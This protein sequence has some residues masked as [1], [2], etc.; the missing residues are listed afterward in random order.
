MAQVPVLLSIDDEMLIP[1]P[2]G[3]EGPRGPSGIGDS[4]DIMEY[5]GTTTGDNT[6][7]LNEA[8]ADC[9]TLGKRMISFPAGMFGFSS[10]PSAIDGIR[11]VGQG[12]TATYLVRNYSGNFLKF[13]GGLLGGSGLE[14]LGVLAGSGTSGGYGIHLVGSSTETP[15]FSTFKSLLVSSGGGTFAFPFLLDGSLRTS[16]QGVRNVRVSNSDFFAGTSGAA[17]IYNGVAVYMDAVGCYPA[18][19]TSGTLYVQG[20][21]TI[22]CM[23]NMNVVGELNLQSLSRLTFSGH[24]SSFYGASSASQCFVIGTKSGSVSNSMT[25]SYVNLA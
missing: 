10:Q 1:G 2:Q 11:I 13:G 7:A 16:P 8:L 25:N 3:D 23:T 4:L 20:G 14:D 17:Q 19:G 24:V 6:A 22:I 9:V 5:G 12:K 15:D 21:S 18:G